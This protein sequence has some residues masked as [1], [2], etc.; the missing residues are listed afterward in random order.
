MDVFEHHRLAGLGNVADNTLSALQHPYPGHMFTVYFIGRP[1]LQFLHLVVKKE[2]PH[3]LEVKYLCGLC[4]DRVQ[5]VI[6]SQGFIHRC[7]DAIECGY[8][9]GPLVDLLFQSVIGVLKS[10]GHLVKFNR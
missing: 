6:Q 5:D 7:R 3:A 8:F 1:Q 4:D 10:V 9:L 2:N